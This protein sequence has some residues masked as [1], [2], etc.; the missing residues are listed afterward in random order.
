MQRQEAE[1][2]QRVLAQ[3]EERLAD[4]QGKVWQMSVDQLEAHREE[5]ERYR[6]ALTMLRDQLKEAGL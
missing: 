2:R 3:W 5:Q 6:A 4:Q 1:A